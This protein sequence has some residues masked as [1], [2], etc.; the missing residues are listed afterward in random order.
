[1]YYCSAAGILWRGDSLVCILTIT[2]GNACGGVF[3]P[4]IRKAAA[5]LGK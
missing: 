4:L 3:I 2:L 5:K 1:M